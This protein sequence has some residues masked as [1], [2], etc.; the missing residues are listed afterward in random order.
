MSSQ[1]RLTPSPRDPRAAIAVAMRETH[2]FV[3]LDVET[4]NG[5][6]ASICQIGLCCVTAEGAMTTLGFLVDP[7]APFEP[8]NTQLHGIDAALVR[9]APDFSQIIAPLRPLLERQPLV[10][11]SGFDRRAMQAA[12][13][14]DGLVPLASVWHDSVRVARRAWPELKGNGGHGLASLKTHLGLRF[15]HHDAAEDA[16]AAAQVVLHA[17]AATGHPFDMLAP[18]TRGEGATTRRRFA[19]SRAEPVAGSRDGP[20]FGLVACFTGRLSVPRADAIAR[21]TS[22]GITIAPAVTPDVAMLVVPDLGGLKLPDPQRGTGSAKRRAAEALI[23]QGH[24]LRIVGEAEF[25]ALIG[26]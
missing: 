26:G 22:A 6:P 14:R 20:L 7:R 9:A 11:H 15:E 24:A 4:A 3:A 21:A 17:E 12:C 10:Q 8:F 25:L 19:G 13:A 23:E 5:D 1:P 18:G 16:R 2:R